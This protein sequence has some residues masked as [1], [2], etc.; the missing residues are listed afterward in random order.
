MKL[1][2]RG[3]GAL[4]AAVLAAATGPASA[5]A[6]GAATPPEMVSA[7]DALADVIL[8]SR[9]AE[10]KLVLS[11]LAASYGHA[12]AELARARQSLKAADA[13]GARGAVENLAAAVGQIGTEGDNAVAGVRK[14]LLEGGHH[15]N[16]EGEAQGVYDE[17]YVVVTKAA[18]Q[19]FLDAS[20]A[21]AMLARDPKAEALDNE[22]KKVE[23][24]WAKHIASAR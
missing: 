21:I 3:S 16:A 22:W 10:K 2:K 1:T 5:Q 11:L 24:A 18:K 14:R 20:K 17:G 12:Q 8:G 7:Y 6:R 19:A 23:A 4:L 13:V 15:A 9:K